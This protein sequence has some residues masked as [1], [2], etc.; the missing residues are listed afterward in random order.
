MYSLRVASGWYHKNKLRGRR[1]RGREGRGEGR[2]GVGRG[3]G[4]RGVGRG[5]ERRG[6]EGREGEEREEERE[7]RRYTIV[8][9]YFVS[10]C[11]TYFCAFS[12]ESDRFP[13]VF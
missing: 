3:E 6:E 8:I 4:R 10:S 9:S 2:R 11:P 7:K 13:E 1:R 5:E 12:R